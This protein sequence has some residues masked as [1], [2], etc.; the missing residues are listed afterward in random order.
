MK[1][2]IFPLTLIFILLL[3]FTLIG[4]CW[5]AGYDQRIKLTIDHTKIDD[6]LT[7]FPVTAFFTAA[8]AEE[9]FSEFDADEDFDRGQFALGDDT[10]L[11][12]E[13][14]WFDVS[15]SMGGYHI[16]IPS[17]SSSVDTDYY[18]YYDNDAD[19]N[20]SYIGI[21]GSATAAEVWVDYAAVYHMV[22]VE[23]ATT[24]KFYQKGAAAYPNDGQVYIMD[25]ENDFVF[26]NFSYTSDW[27]EVEIDLTTP[28][29]SS[30]T[31]NWEA[32]NKYR[33]DLD[34]SGRTVYIDN[35][36]F[37]NVNG[38]LIHSNMCESITDWLAAT[39]GTR[40]LE[41]TIIQEG[42][43]SIKLV[44]TDNDC[45]SY[46]DPTGTWGWASMI[47]DS[48]SNS[49]DGTKKAA[50]EPVEVDG[51]VGKA[52]DFDGA[53]D[54]ISLSQIPAITVNGVYIIE[55]FIKLDT[56]NIMRAIFS[57][58]IS[59]SNRMTLALNVEDKIAGEHYNGSIYQG[60]KSTD[61]AVDTGIYYH[62]A[63]VYNNTVGKLYLN[64][65]EQSGTASTGGTSSDVAT[66][67]GSRSNG[68][69]NVWDGLIN[70]VRISNTNR[71][72][73][74]IKATYNTLWDSLLTYGS[75]ETKPV[76]EE[77]NALF[78]FN[79]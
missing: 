70:E 33:F 49:N 20:T 64:G 76:E 32:V 23:Q 65:D 66:K 50:N 12:A 75:E 15:E 53:N 55:G 58:T 1:K 62:I 73:A 46:Y 18:F 77:G 79:F 68:I 38:T 21:I 43:G 40:S 51:K 41:T 47:L 11:K 19:H 35:I 48:T 39:R 54:Y 7:N 37:Y 52:Q 2:L 25:S 8:Q 10:L 29:G 34:T 6:T 44:S 45:F 59:G 57:Q 9:I 3:T 30:G 16:K 78:W 28:D 27:Q 72:A 24:M 63:Y 69:D 60:T 67:I 22:D 36:R 71:S 14:E 4:D 26:Y 5:V 17:I 42:S 74:W 31:M 13:N 56:K 61:L